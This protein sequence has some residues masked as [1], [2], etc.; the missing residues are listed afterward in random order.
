MTLNLG[1]N[2]S[3]IGFNLIFP[4][5]KKGVKGAWK[6]AKNQSFDMA[7]MNIKLGRE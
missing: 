7:L 3:T 1:G 6:K 4:T 2:K 5:S